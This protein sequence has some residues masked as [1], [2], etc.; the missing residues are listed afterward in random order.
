MLSPSPFPCSVRLGKMIYILWLV[1]ELEAL[2]N[3]VSGLSFMFQLSYLTMMFST[4]GFKVNFPTEELFSPI[5]VVPCVFS[6]HNCVQ[7]FIK[8]S[9]R[10]SP[11]LMHIWRWSLFTPP[12]LGNL[13][14]FSVLFQNNHLFNDFSAYVSE[15][16]YT[17]MLC[18]HVLMTRRKQ[19]ESSIS[20]C[21][22]LWGRQGL[23]LKQ[24]AQVF[25]DR[26]AASKIW[27][28]FYFYPFRSWC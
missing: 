17:H 2:F 4:K 9:W 22:F 19:E 7:W 5:S 18:V 13:L 11:F 6:E 14:F 25:P 23:S 12:S 8:S 20:P 16:V 3:S 10:T 27:F 1:W 21:L 24:E 15:K 28:S 26:L